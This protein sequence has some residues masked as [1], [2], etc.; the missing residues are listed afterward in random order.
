[1]A[2]STI[3]VRQLNAAELTSFVSGVINAYPKTTVTGSII[4]SGSGVANLGSSSY[5]YSQIY[6]N[7]L[8]LP[9][10]SG[11]NFGPSF[12]RAYN[13]GGFAYVSVGGVTISSSGDY[14]YIAGPSG[15]QG[16]SGVQG[17]TGVSGVGVTGATYNTNSHLLTFY[18]SNGGSNSFNF[19]GLSGDTGVSV[20][21]FFQSG[22][23]IYPQFDHF[24]GTGSPILLVAGPAGP[25]GGINLYFEKSGASVF[26]NGT[27]FPSNVIIDPYY[28]ST[29]SP[30]I[31]LL[32]GGAYTFDVSGLNTYTITSADTGLYQIVFSGQSV[33]FSAGDK[34]NYFKSGDSTGY[35]RM[36]FFP[37]GTATGYYTGPTGSYPTIFSETSNFELYAN[38]VINNSYRTNLSCITN[39]R[40][41]DKYKY[42]FMVYTLDY[43]NTIDTILGPTG[44]AYVL[45]DAYV[46]SGIG[47]AG[48]QG[49]AGTGLTGS[50]GDK[51]DKGDDGEGIVAYTYSGNGDDMYIRFTLSNGTSQPWIPLPKGGPSG[52][53]GPAGSISNSFSGEWI[54]SLYYGPNT[55]VTRQGSSYVNT[56]T[57]AAFNITP[58]TAP[59][60]MLAASGASGLQ[61]IQGIQGPSGA[62]GTLSNHFSGTWSAGAAYPNDYI[63]VLSGSSYVNTGSTT[64]PGVSPPNAPWQMLAQKGD[65]GPQGLSG[66][67]SLLRPQITGGLL[68]GRTASTSDS[69]LINPDALDIFSVSIEKGPYGD[70]IG[71]PAVQIVISGN[72]FPVGKSII[73]NIR[74]IDVVQND[75]Q[76]SPIFNFPSVNVSGTGYNIKWPNQVYSLPN[77]GTSHIYTI[78]RF[79]DETDVPAFYGTYSNPY[80]L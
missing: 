33:P 20:T 10:G 51:G 39:F 45:G 19:Q 71:I 43:D 69:V 66:V 70:D 25:P 30:P 14:V 50:K 15:K 3:R 1:M 67:P 36:A 47:P 65:T 78:L 13:S 54:N 16:P 29:A 60:Q 75:N 63:V 55:I 2:D 46:S 23:F 35:W 53:A 59:W 32:R 12:F 8:N 22:A 38:G 34:I 49:P 27:N 74:N 44:Y 5:P 64:T 77:L 28:Y 61:G 24:K 7:Q 40:A 9:S 68:Y 48:P 6:A 41:K 72:N 76:H 11:I 26:S 62:A 42:G 18:Y 56:G 57:S 17:P 37:S 21:G 73:I 52:E 31:S 4:P 80:F 58:P 79:P